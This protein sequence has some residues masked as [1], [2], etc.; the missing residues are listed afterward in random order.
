MKRTERTA[1]RV[2]RAVARAAALSGMLA[3]SGL[4]AGVASAAG[5]H[6]P[7]ARSA[8]VSLTYQCRFPDG[9]HPVTVGVTAA[10]PVV[11]ATGRPIR[12]RGISLTMALPPAA[13]SGLAGL[14]AA[15]VSATTRLTVSASEGPSGA[16][17]TWPGSTAHPVPL[18]ARGGLTLTTAGAVPPVSASSPGQVLLTAA[19]LSVT[20]IAGRATVP[21]PSPAPSATSPPPPAPSPAQPA[22]PAAGGQAASPAPAA[23][24]PATAGIPLQVNCTPAPGQHAT[25]GAVLVTGK[26]HGAAR[27]AAVTAKCPKLPPGGLK[28]NPRFPLPKPPPGSTIGGSPS[29][30][31]AYTTGYADARKLKGAALIQPG[32][33]NVDLFVR[34]VTNFNPKID[35]FEAD[36]AAVL[37]YHGKQ[38]FPPSTATFLT[39]GFTPTTATIQLIEHGAINIIIVGPA[40]PPP[41]H[42]NKYQSCINLATVY[43]RLS[44]R[45]VPGSV[46]VNG[47]PLDVGSHCG[48]S[49]FDAILTGNSASKPPYS[50]TG[51]GPITGFVSI[52]KFSGCGVTENL[53]PIF[54]AAI[55]GPRNFNLLTQGAVCFVV[56]GQ[57]CNPQTGLPVIPKPVR[58]VIG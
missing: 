22:T 1:R 6:A 53:D 21:A 37:D 38:E 16:S 40:L 52:P 39:F 5:G 28:L 46:T 2:P 19:G 10:I 30:A 48:T 35:Y 45:I 27:H 13:V 23:T 51:G 9:P 41:C 25:L 44:V 49:A 7:G 36:N 24:A 55:S 15:S 20:F 57:G 3:A 17:L 31:C 8:A 14:H 34:T 29:Q 43:S 42:P 58:K 11:A 54:N 12:P 56:G 33:T 4:A 26:P 32:L 18:P 47:V 50:V